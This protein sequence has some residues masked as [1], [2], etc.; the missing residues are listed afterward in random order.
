MPDIA[1]AR[2]AVVGTEDPRIALDARRLAMNPA[3]ARRCEEHFRPFRMGED[4]VQ[5]RVAAGKTE[6]PAFA[7][8]V[9]A[10]YA[11]DL[12]AEAD[13]ARVLAVDRQRAGARLRRRRHRQTPLRRAR[14]AG[15]SRTFAPR[16]AVVVAAKQGRRLRRGID[17]R[18]AGAAYLPHFAVGK[19]GETPRGAIVIGHEQP[20]IRAREQTVADADEIAHAAAFEHPAR[21]VGA[22]GE[23]AAVGSR[24]NGHRPSP[25]PS[26]RRATAV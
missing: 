17:G 22:D 8:V 18:P 21:A 20:F 11:A 23:H 24:E 7:A 1:P 13:T 12:D 4:H 26:A 25:P 5:V 6:G 2:A 3:V 14:E 15:D 19:A 9:A 16:R 10:D